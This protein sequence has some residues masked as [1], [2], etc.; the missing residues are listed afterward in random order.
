[1]ASA[2]SSWLLTHC[3]PQTVLHRLL[4][5]PAALLPACL[6]A[7]SYTQ[8]VVALAPSVV[9]VRLSICVRTHQVLHALANALTC[10]GLLVTSWWPCKAIA[11]AGWMG[12]LP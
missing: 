8:L 6:L 1:M 7:A 11:V 10:Q 5:F 4:F 9:G 12:L 2:F 3:R